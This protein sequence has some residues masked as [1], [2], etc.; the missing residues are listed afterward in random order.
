MEAYFREFVNYKKKDWDRLLLMPKFD[1]NN[2]KNAS[3]GHMLFE[4]NCHFYLQTFYK[5]DVN[6]CY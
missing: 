2:A 6:F 3:N 5:E 4:L 1:N